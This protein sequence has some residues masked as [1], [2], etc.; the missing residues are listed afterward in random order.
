MSRLTNPTVPVDFYLIRHRGR[1]L[2][3]AAEAFTA[4]LQGYVARWAGRAGVP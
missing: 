4:F 3:P 2:S 1:K